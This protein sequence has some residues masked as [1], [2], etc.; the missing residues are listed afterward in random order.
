MTRTEAEQVISRELEPGE[1]PLWTGI[2]KQGLM[3]RPSDAM[4]IPFSLLWGGFAIFWEVSVLS[5]GAPVFFALWGVPFV[6]VGLYLIAGRFVVEARQRARTAYAITNKRAIIVSGLLSRSVKSLPLHTLAEVTLSERSD[7]SGAIVLG[8]Q[9]V[10]GHWHAGASWPGMSSQLAPT[11]DLIENA[12]TVYSQ[13][14]A[15]QSEASRD[16]G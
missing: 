13:L 6:V 4:L 1:L 2:P 7:G 5:M 3:L 9:P 15:A 12:R 14:R 16:A 10:W 8:A 11:F